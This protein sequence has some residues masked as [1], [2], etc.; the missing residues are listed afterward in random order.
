MI[1]IILR[2]ILLSFLAIFQVNAQ[3]EDY[4]EHITSNDGLSQNDVLCVYQDALGFMWFGTND[5]LNKYDGYSF[6]IYKTRNNDPNSIVGNLF[7]DITED[8]QG[9]LWIATLGYGL[10]LYERTTHKFSNFQNDPNDDNTLI[11]NGVKNLYC[12]RQNRM[13]LITREGVDMFE[14]P[15]EEKKE[16][17][18]KH[19]FRNEGVNFNVIHEDHK[20]TIL[21]G[22]VNGLFEVVEKNNALTLKKKK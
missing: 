15:E 4:F 1:K 19:L 11:N 10:N 13:W 6:D 8:Q 18:F 12:D 21:L 9:D 22:S 2:S 16:I 7:M 3:V 5:G 17:S 14:I 20:G